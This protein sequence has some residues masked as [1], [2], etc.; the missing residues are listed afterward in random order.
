M[1]SKELYLPVIV[2]DFEVGDRVYCLTKEMDYGLFGTVKSIQESS[3]SVTMD[4]GGD[5]IVAIYLF[6]KTT[7]VRWRRCIDIKQVVAGSLLSSEV[8]D[9]ETGEVSTTFCRVEKM[10]GDE[11]TLTYLDDNKTFSL[12]ATER[13]PMESILRNWVL[14]P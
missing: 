11:I 1:N 3:V 4:N 7:G 2:E 5:L 12:Y 9:P 6:G 14:E 8:Q 13:S 10:I